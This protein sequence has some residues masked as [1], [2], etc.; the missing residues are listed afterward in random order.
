MT[1]SDW[2]LS[3][4]RNCCNSP[5]HGEPEE[6]E[7]FL[8]DNNE[9]PGVSF[10]VDY[11]VRRANLEDLPILRGLWETACLPVLELE[12]R[13]TD[14]QVAQ[15]SDGVIVGVMGL[16]LC[17]GHGL[18]YGESFSSGLQEKL[19]RPVL[20][21]RVLFLAR[22]RGCERLWLKGTGTDF[23]RS[24]GFRDPGQDELSVLPKAFGEGSG[25]WL[26]MVV[27]ENSVVSEQL[28]ERLA[29]LRE[30]EQSRTDRIR[31]QARLFKALAGLIVLGFLVGTAWLMFKLLG[32]APR[33]QIQ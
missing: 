16:R 25:F 29:E 14:F 18:V 30:E 20:W 5:F 12:K 26:T 1:G 32:L 8:Q 19:V 15:R 3:Q 24:A 23:W 28:A 27:R 6:M 17:G 11:R 9:Q 7:A 21:E 13:L 2:L 33:T 4:T 10:P 31:F 22:N